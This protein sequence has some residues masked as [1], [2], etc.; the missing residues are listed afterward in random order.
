MLGHAR[1]QRSHNTPRA[2]AAL[3]QPTRGLPAD[4][5][6]DAQ[7]GQSFYVAR[8]KAD[9]D[10]LARLGEHKLIPG[11]PVELFIETDQRTALS[12]LVKPMTDQFARAFKGR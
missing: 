2:V 11:M 4:L 9:D 3:T 12:Y 6:R 1:K 5:S 8:I 10:A 7:T